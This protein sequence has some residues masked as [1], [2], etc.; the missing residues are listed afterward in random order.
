MIAKMTI[1]TRRDPLAQV[2]PDAR[3]WELRDSMLLVY[4]GEQSVNGFP[5]C[6]VVRF[7]CEPHPVAEQVVEITEEQP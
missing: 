6:D 7:E 2:Y 4:F 1:W 5:V 3:G